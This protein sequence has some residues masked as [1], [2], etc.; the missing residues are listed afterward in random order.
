MLDEDFLKFNRS[1]IEA[2]EKID[3]L[4]ACSITS[5]GNWINASVVKK[6]TERALNCN[7]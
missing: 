2:L 3:T 6:I 4:A 1:L 7:G 5:G